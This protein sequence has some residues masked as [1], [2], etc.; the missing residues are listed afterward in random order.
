M[1][2]YVWLL[3]GNIE[4]DYLQRKQAVVRHMPNSVQVSN[5]CLYVC[6]CAL[7][8]VLVCAVVCVLVCVLVCVF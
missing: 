1:Y 8:C 2:L 7:E 3:F 6:E 4:G 5:E